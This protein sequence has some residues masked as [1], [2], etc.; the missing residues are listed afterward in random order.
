MTGN[1]RRR[2]LQP[3]VEPERADQRFASV[4]EVGGV[5]APA[6]AR[7][8]R[9]HDE[10]G[11]EID[12]AGDP[13]Q[14][15]PADQDGEASRQ[16]ALVFGRVRRHQTVGDDQAEHAVAEELQT[17]IVD[18]RP[19]AG[20]GERLGEPRRRTERN[21]ERV[22][23]GRRIAGAG[24]GSAAHSPSKKRPSRQ[25]Q[26]SQNRPSTEM[27]SISARPIRFSMGM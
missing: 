23:G 17:L 1:E 12:V 14:G 20:M 10:V 27:N 4:G 2:L 5:V 7:F 26:N 24:R 19:G 25:F 21:A 6:A 22:G 13:G 9:V 3:A 15:F 18:S 8:R 16:G 11:P